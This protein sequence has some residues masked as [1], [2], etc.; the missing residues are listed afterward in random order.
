LNPIDDFT[1]A[2]KIEPDNNYAYQARG[3]TQFIFDDKQG[4]IVDFTKAID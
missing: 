2:I 1:Q 4:A 3:Y